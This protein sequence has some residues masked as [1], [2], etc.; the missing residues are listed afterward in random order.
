MSASEKS[1]VKGMIYV[2]VIALVITGLFAIMMFSPTP[3][4]NEPLI[5]TSIRYYTKGTEKLFYGDYAGLIAQN[6]NEIGIKTDIYQMEYATYL[7]TVVQNREYDLAILE[8]EGEDAPHVEQFLREGASL[9]IFNF[10]NEIDNGYTANLTNEILQERDKQ[11]RIA[12]F[13]DLQYHIMDKVLPFIPLFTPVRTYIF[14]DNLEEFEEDWGISNSLPYMYF[15]GL[16]PKQENTNELRI[17]IGRW[18]TL[19]PILSREPGE[20][21]I[22]S[23][24]MDKLILTDPSGRPTKYG[25]IKNWQYE[26][27]TT[28][29][30]NAR[31]NAYWQSD[32]YGQ[33][34]D[35]PFVAADVALTL[36]LFKSSEVNNN[37]AMYKWIKNVEIVNDTAVR[38]YIDS[39]PETPENEPYAYV[40]EDLSIYPY[41]SFYLDNGGTID[42]ILD[43]TE[44]HDYSLHPFGTGKYYIDFGETET[45]LSVVLRKFEKWY[46]EGVFPDK[47][48]NLEFDTII[49]KPYQDTY[50]MMLELS[51]GGEID[52]GD[53]GKDPSTIDSIFEEGLEY[54]VTKENSLIILAINLESKNFG[55]E[56]NYES[57]NETDLSVGLALRKAIASI[58]DKNLINDALHKNFY[59][60]TDS[61]IPTYY[62]DYYYSEVP[63]Y[64]KSLTDA[65]NYLELAGIDIE[66]G[67]NDTLNSPYSVIGIYTGIIAMVITTKLSK[68]YRL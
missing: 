55:G 56:K 5:S 2:F 9:N 12:L 8:I 7:E 40:L 17:G 59:N 46:N 52:I 48:P 35:Q 54:A 33:F 11:A 18:S 29:L 13:Y 60:V 65:I 24:V 44:W 27:A 61:I 39:D 23:M 42:D 64:G 51:Q 57:T 58:I 16:H 4:E 10:K 37:Y 30:L 3:S 49:A 31:S 6:L 62:T 25:L 36:R 63:R 34:Q 14:W 68:K 41:P 43:S 38:I 19:S 45:G 22:L 20:K 67:R 53:F 47:T 32:Y 21:M 66:G 28:I 1:V 26:N 15:N 50:A